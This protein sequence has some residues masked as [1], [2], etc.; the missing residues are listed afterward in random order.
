MMFRVLVRG[1]WFAGV[2]LC[3]LKRLGM[4]GIVA[5]IMEQCSLF[6]PLRWG[7]G[8]MA[9]LLWLEWVT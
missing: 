1:Y 7:A 5:N 6:L 8:P 2:F 3:F 9:L 4:F